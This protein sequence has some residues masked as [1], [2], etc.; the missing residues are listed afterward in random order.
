[1][2]DDEIEDRKFDFEAWVRDARF[3]YTEL[4]TRK[5]EIREAV[6][7]LLAE[8]VVVLSQCE[9]VEKMLAAMGIKPEENLSRPRQSNI[10]TVAIEVIEEMFK[11]FPALVAVD[12][13][14]LIRAVSVRL[15]DA[16]EKSIQGA[17]YRL[18]QTNSKVSRK[19]KRGSYQYTF[20]DVVIPDQA[21]H[22]IDA[23]V[24]DEV[25]DPDGGKLVS[26]GIYLNP[27]AVN[28]DRI[29]DPDKSKT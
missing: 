3:G 2:D 17:F 28:P 29:L 4:K 19:G 21:P 7:T 20:S 22:P 23:P 27:L 18:T 25:V 13:S 9:K 1:M 16:K 8:E 12:E 14:E 26:P 15:P 11:K 24:P 10:A 5:K 6:E